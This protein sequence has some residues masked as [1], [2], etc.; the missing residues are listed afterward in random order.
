MKAIESKA[1]SGDFSQVAAL[2]V[3]FGDDGVG[4]VLLLTSRATKRWMPN[5][6]FSMV[7]GRMD[8]SAATHP[9]IL[10]QE[11]RMVLSKR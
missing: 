5:Q 3:M 11:A 4:R 10:A 9:A 7:A 6:G 2:P 1:Q 8:C